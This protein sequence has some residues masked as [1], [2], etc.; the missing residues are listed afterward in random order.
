[1]GPAEEFLNI[2]INQRL[3]KITIDQEPYVRTILKKYKAYI[4]CRNYADVPSMSEY[5]PRD[6][7][8]DFG[9]VSQSGGQGSQRG[10]SGNDSRYKEEE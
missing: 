5:I 8:P 4:G 3:G 7:P 1:M 9:L 2:R 6:E 10:H